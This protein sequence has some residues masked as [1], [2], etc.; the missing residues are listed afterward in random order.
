MDVF[1]HPPTTIPTTQTPLCSPLYYAYARKL[2]I[3][4]AYSLKSII[5]IYIYTDNKKNKGVSYRAI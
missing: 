1:K 3:L 5:Y 4:L 2:L